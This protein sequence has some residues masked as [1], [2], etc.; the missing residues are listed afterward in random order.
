MKRWINH[1]RVLK[2]VVV[3]ERW[4][5]DEL[6]SEMERFRFSILTWLTNGS[7]CESPCQP[8]SQQTPKPDP[9]RK[10]IESHSSPSS[11][12]LDVNREPWHGTHSLFLL[13]PSARAHVTS[14]GLASRRNPHGLVQ[15]QKKSNN[16]KWQTR[17]IPHFWLYF[18]SFF[19]FE[20][21]KRIQAQTRLVVMNTEVINTWEE[22]ITHPRWSLPR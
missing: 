20:I 22:F 11:S 16:K 6:I 5:S 4:Q 9:I 2:S 21:V 14:V 7:D 1:F 18:C 12:Y 19:R 13:Q 10:W 3:A 17:R 8:K 15:K